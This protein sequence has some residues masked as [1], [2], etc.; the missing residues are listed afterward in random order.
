M[1]PHQILQNTGQTQIE[2][3]RHH[4]KQESRAVKTDWEENICG[5]YFC[6]SFLTLKVGQWKSYSMIV[7]FVPPLFFV[8]FFLLVLQMSCFRVGV[9]VFTVSK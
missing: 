4:N 1:A 9:V 2:R 7:W 5:V 8:L 6:V 3:K